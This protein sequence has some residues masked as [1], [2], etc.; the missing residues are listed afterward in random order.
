MTIREVVDAIL[1]YHPPIDAPRSCDGFKSGSPEDEC[2]GIVTT[3]MASVEVIRKTIE[4]GYNLIITHEPTFYNHFDQVDWLEGRDSVYDEKRK[5]L[6]RY[7]IA[8]FRDHDHIHAHKPDGIY[9]G[10]MKELGWESFRTGAAERPCRFSLPRTTVRELALSLKVTFN[11]N[12]IRVFGNLD[13]KVSTL[14]FCGHVYP[15]VPEQDATRLLEEV[16]VVIP[17]EII[18]WTVAAYARDAA[19]LGMDKAIIHLGHFN[20]EE[21]GMRWAPTWIKKLVAPSL[22]ISFVPSGDLYNYL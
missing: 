19:Q 17:G 6:D 3:C 16:D 14:A 9:T 12:G 11:L 2:R 1:A 7:G 21:L 10:M 5:L 13:G 15:P 22:P 18:D 4:L 8:V 20:M